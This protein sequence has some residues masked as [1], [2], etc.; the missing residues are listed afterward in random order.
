MPHFVHSILVIIQNFPCFFIQ[1]KREFVQTYH[2]KNIDGY[3]WGLH[4]N[5]E[6]WTVTQLDPDSQASVGF[7]FRILKGWKLSKIE[8]NRRLLIA[9]K[10][11]LQEIKNILE[12]QNENCSIT[13]TTWHD[14]RFSFEGE[15]F[16]S[17]LS[18]MQ[19]S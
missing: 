10:E 14:V 2:F 15:N 4:I 18:R 12:M 7:R 17:W 5:F 19:K 9:N 1:L 11:N 6:D 3:A 13:F 8:I 16:F